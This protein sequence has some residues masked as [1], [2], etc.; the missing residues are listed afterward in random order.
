MRF[1]E[2][3]P[4]PLSPEFRVGFSEE[5][6]LALARVFLAFLEKG[7]EPTDDIAHLALVLSEVLNKAGGD[8]FRHYRKIAHKLKKSSSKA[9]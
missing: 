1:L 7:Q 8:D 9:R 4:I 6:L 5:D 2:K 3:L